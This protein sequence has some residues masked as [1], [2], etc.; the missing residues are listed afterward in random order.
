MIVENGTGVP[1][2][3]SYVTVLEA[4]AYLASRGVPAAWAALDDTAKAALLVRATDYMQAAYRGRWKGFRRSDTQAL[5]WPRQGVMLDDLPYGALVKFDIVP[6]Q[7]KAAQIELATRQMTAGD[8][9]LMQ[10]LTRGVVSET[11]GPISTTYDTHSPQQVRYAQVD[12]LLSPLLATTGAMM[13]L[14]RS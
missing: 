7:V 1:D 12:A 14:G 13:K 2:A 3:D 10:D 6:G 11:I 8:T 5:D 4:D 9:P